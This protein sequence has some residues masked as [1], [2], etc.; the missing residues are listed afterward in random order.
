MLI[1]KIKSTEITFVDDETARL[2]RQLFI[3]GTDDPGSFARNLA[4]YIF[5]QDRLIKTLMGR[6]GKFLKGLKDCD[7]SEI[8]TAD[9]EL[10]VLK[11]Y[12]LID[13]DLF[14]CQDAF[15]FLIRN[16]INQLGRDLKKK[17]LEE[18]DNSK[19]VRR[20]RQKNLRNSKVP[21]RPITSY[22]R[23][24]KRNANTCQDP[25]RPSTSK[26]N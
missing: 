26:E 4:I 23:I 18:Q 24:E 1:A 3:Y 21:M 17:S 11:L 2:I 20:S 6:D 5:G 16:P 19:T 9:E 10:Q 13:E 7:R 25:N 22:F 8:F 12:M 15:E 14:S